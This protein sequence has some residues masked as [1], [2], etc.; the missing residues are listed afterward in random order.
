[1]V[2]YDG[3]GHINIIT[4]DLEKAAAGEEKL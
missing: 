4:D 2:D 1:M 3:F